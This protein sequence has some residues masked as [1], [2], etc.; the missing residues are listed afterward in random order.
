MRSPDS[1]TVCLR[2]GLTVPVAAVVLALDLEAR[3]CTLAV[4][5]DG[6]LIGPPT[7]L[8]DEDRAAIRACKADLMALID[9]VDHVVTQ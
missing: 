9:Y 6:L 2:S 5:G 4:D 7:L 8:S 1:E 3:G